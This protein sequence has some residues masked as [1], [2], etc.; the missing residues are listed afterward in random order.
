[1]NPKHAVSL[2]RP[3]IS[4]PSAERQASLLRSWDMLQPG[5]GFEIR[6]CQWESSMRL[7]H[8]LVNKADAESDHLEVNE[9][10]LGYLQYSSRTP[11]LPA[12]SPPPTVPVPYSP[13]LI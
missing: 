7:R 12:D 11:G 3:I 1:M 6:T 8:G 13:F 10:A 5:A 2:S 9:L 4:M